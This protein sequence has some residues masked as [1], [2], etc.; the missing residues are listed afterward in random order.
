MLRLTQLATPVL[1]GEERVSVCILTK[2]LTHEPH[3][4][5]IEP[6]LTADPLFEALKRLRCQLAD[7]ENKPPF[8]IFS[9]ATLRDL[10][11][12]Q[13]QSI[14]ALLSVSGIGQHKLRRYGPAILLLLKKM[15]K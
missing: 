11:R 10:M 2:T 8:M 9:D 4:K 1:R 3:K 13:P 14:E 12:I 15:V 6:N 7:E 5:M